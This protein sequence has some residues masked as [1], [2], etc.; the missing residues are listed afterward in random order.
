MNLSS[1]KSLFRDL[2]LS[3]GSE[4]RRGLLI[5]YVMMILM[6]A[7]EAISAGLFVP[8]TSLLAG[9]ATVA[10]YPILTKISA[11]LS[12]P[13]PYAELLVS[14]AA[15]SLA[16]AAKNIYGTY[17][18]YYRSS[19]VRR[20]HARFATRLLN[21]YLHRPYA[22]HV[23]HNSSELLRNI[24]QD[25]NNVFTNVLTCALIILVEM[26][27]AST[28]LV[29]M[30]MNMPAL[31]ILL[32]VGF[33]CVSAVFLRLTQ[34]SLS[35]LGEQQRHH[36]SLMLKWAMQGLGGIKEVKIMAREAYFTQSFSDHIEHF[37]NY[38]ARYTLLR[39]T[40]RFF[41]ETAGI[42]VMMLITLLLVWNTADSATILPS[43]SFFAV[44]AFR[45]LPS[46]SRITQA[47]S[48]LR[49][50]APSLKHVCQD[51]RAGEQTDAAAAAQAAAVVE[52]PLPF[53][54]EITIKDLVFSHQGA[55]KPLFNSLSLR[56]ERGTSVAFVG[57]SGAG[58]TTLVDLM[59]GLL[60]PESGEICVDGAKINA[61][62]KAWQKQL[63]YI[64]QPIYLLD[65]T[66][67][68]NI[69]FG[70]NDDLI[71]DEKVWQMLKLAQLDDAIRA[72]PNQ[73]DTVI[74][75]GGMMLSGGQRQR[76]GIARVLYRDPQVLVFDEATSALDAVT[77]HEI[78]RAI[79]QLHGLKT[80]II[81]AHRLSTIR[82]CD[83]IFLLEAG[84]VQDQGTFTQLYQQ[85]AQFKRMV[86]LGAA[87]Q[88]P[89]PQ[90]SEQP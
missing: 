50:F 8:F 1:L 59:L 69:A 66:I 80:I 83:Q 71:D 82:S 89:A 76:L 24:T 37:A 54:R 86:E 18:I 49:Y 48:T 58:K 27:I 32:M 72:L 33:V 43:L 85:N 28:L 31:G 36:S 68:R 16:F 14:C 21:I 12:L 79:D 2:V 77:E 46:A 23:E 51:V 13:G 67:R 6:A 25:V 39:E 73:L 29:M 75:E 52:A 41:I 20:C 55:A 30:V 90:D 81:I 34:R 7:L 19:F 22:F 84:K 9:H 64:S 88:A 10:D 5:I 4:G 60:S 35:H 63:G 47:L 45:M 40:P 70:L 56:I 15:L 44:A 74:G 3:V 78:Q 61:H 42:F 26:I 53:E 62:I 87:E 17:Y 38:N 65:D 11:A 57:N